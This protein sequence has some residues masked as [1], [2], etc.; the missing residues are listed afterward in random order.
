MSAIRT[1]DV[2]SP[3]VERSLRTFGILALAVLSGHVMQ[4]PWTRYKHAQGV[5]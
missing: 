5:G 2:I 3:R 1:F 4:L